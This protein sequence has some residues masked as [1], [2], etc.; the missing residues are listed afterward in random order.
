MGRAIRLRLIHSQRL[1]RECLQAAL[2]H[3]GMQVVASDHSSPVD[4]IYRNGRGENS[5]A[6][7][8]LIFEAG[9]ANGRAAVLVRQLVE[10]APETKVILLVGRQWTDSIG[11]C[12]AAGAQG[13]VP[14]DSSL[15]Q[16]VQAVE[17]VRRGEVFCCPEMAHALI[18]QMARCDEDSSAVRRSAA[19]LTPRE[20]EVLS[21]IAQRLSNK[22]IARRLFVS[23]F[24]VKNHVHNILEKLQVADR[25]EAVELAHRKQW[26]E[27]PLT[28]ST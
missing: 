16:L 21:L 22:Q 6:P 13:I 10:E 5:S 11:E 9:S 15:T 26:L 18:R 4:P 7:E 23:P 25:Q 12:A 1:F 27:G 24:T 2:E 14:E 3:R 8:V 19:K 17:R 20:R 28:A